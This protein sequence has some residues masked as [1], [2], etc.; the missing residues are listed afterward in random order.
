MGG[1][2]HTGGI[3]VGGI[4]VLQVHPLPLV[5]VLAVVLG[6]SAVR[7]AGLAVDARGLVEAAGHGLAGLI[8]DVVMHHCDSR[9]TDGELPG[10]GASDAENCDANRQLHYMRCNLWAGGCVAKKRQHGARFQVQA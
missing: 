6:L 7:V 1:G 4:G 10:A 3:V 5:D 2:V 8:V 9:A